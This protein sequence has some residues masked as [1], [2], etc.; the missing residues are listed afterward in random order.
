M[1]KR[2]IDL[3]NAVGEK[4]RAAANLFDKAKRKDMQI[5]TCGIPDSSGMPHYYHQVPGASLRAFSF[6]RISFP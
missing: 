3:K 5:T 2:K 4:G 6:Q 1:E